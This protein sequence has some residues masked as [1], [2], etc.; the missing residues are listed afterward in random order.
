MAH[1]WFFDI[2]SRFYEWTPFLRVALFRLQDEAIDLLAPQ[3]GEHVLDLGCGPARGSK[4]LRERGARPIAADYSDGMVA[5]AAAHLGPGAAVVRLDAMQLPFADGV[6]DAVLCTNSFHHYPEPRVCLREMRRVLR[7]GGRLV[8]VD[9]S[10][11]SIVSRLMVHVGEGFL[12][13][14]E[15][16]HVHTSDEWA[17]MLRDAGFATVVARRGGGLSPARRAEVFVQAVA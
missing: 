9:P 10:G 13:R 16:V 1:G 15:G 7:S 17:A 11:E 6:F 4:A 12:F 2:W 3:G 8:L 14:L 5:K